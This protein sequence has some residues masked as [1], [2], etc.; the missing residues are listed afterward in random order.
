MTESARPETSIWD[1]ACDKCGGTFP[2][3]DVT[4]HTSSK[5]Y[6]RY[7]CK[8][9]YCWAEG[10]CSVCRS[11]K[12]VKCIFGYGPSRILC[13]SCAG[14]AWDRNPGDNASGHHQIR[15]AREVDAALDMV[16][17]PPH[18]QGSNGIEAID[19]IEGFGLNFR[20]GSA[21]G[22]LLRYEKKGEPAKDIKKAIWYLQRE[23]KALE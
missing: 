7:E 12:Y 10:E 4:V 11:V 5:N 8:C 23:L 21:V 22:Y 13:R 16:N 1:T 9:G 6:P 14:E 19:V 3:G 18:Y 20:V 17:N 15:T 2:G